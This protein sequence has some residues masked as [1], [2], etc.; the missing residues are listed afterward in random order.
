MSKNI[1]MDLLWCLN[2]AKH[3]LDVKK[4]LTQNTQ[5]KTKTSKLGLN[6][7][8]IQNFKLYEALILV[9]GT[10]KSKKVYIRQFIFLQIA[11]NFS[12]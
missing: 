7:G 1:F 10:F 6:V 11:R 9:S 5:F 8:A 12:E 2:L 4:Q 3:F